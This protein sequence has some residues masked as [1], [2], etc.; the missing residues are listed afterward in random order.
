MPKPGGARR[1]TNKENNK[2]EKLMSDAEGA[3]APLLE[4]AGGRATIRLNRPRHRN[5]L[6][7][8]DLDAL[9][10][11]FDRIEAD[12]AIRVLVLNRPR[13]TVS[14]RSHLHSLAERG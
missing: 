6:E 9:L 7:A 2:K 12:P 13:R 14:A 4:I 11:L 8:D 10:N 1:K 5:R 3:S